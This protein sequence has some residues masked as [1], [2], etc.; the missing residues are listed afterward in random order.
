MERGWVRAR[1]QLK[2]WQNGFDACQAKIH[3]FNAI[4]HHIFHKSYAW[5]VLQSY[6]DGDDYNDGD[7]DDDELCSSTRTVNK[8]LDGERWHRVKKKEETLN[9]C[10]SEREMEIRK[11]TEKLKK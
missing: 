5:N 11:T 9:W 10:E 6:D 2:C 1:K 8:W 7:D 4:N 3:C